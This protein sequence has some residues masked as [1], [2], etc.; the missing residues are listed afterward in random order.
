MLDA[1]TSLLSSAVA[2]PTE[3]MPTE[4]TTQIVKIKAKIFLNYAIDSPPNDI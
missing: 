3:R 4:H 2:A 1:A